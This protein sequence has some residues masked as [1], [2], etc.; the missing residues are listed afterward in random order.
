MA[1]IG[2]LWLSLFSLNANAQS[3][4]VEGRNYQHQYSIT[5]IPVGQAYYRYSFFGQIIGVFQ[6]WKSA[7]WDSAIGTQYVYVWGR[8]GW[9]YVSYT[10]SY[11]WF[12]WVVYEKR[13][14]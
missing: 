14:G 13:V 7:E 4:Y 5:D 2:M 10:G 11:Y 9:E 6:M 1:L 3:G 12:N 8:N